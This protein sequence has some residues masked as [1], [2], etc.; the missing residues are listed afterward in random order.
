MGLFLELD[1]LRETRR[2]A[3][4]RVL[5]EL[6]LGFW[7][8]WREKKIK[9]LETVEKKREEEEFRRSIEGVEQARC[10]GNGCVLPRILHLRIFV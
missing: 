9:V 4:C 3:E 5:E 7:G 2:G 10:I 8:R 1:C 6:G